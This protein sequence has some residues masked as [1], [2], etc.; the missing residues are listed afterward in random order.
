MSFPKGVGGYQKLFPHNSLQLSWYTYLF[1]SMSSSHWTPCQ[2]N[3]N[4]NFLCLLSPVCRLMLPS[5]HLLGF[6][7]LGAGLEFDTNLEN[8][9]CS[10][11]PAGLPFFNISIHCSIELGVLGNKEYKGFFLSL[12]KLIGMYL[13]VS[14]VLILNLSIH[15]AS[16]KSIF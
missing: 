8:I 3:S 10:F 16:S 12:G 14:H 5:S 7:F 13:F 11:L 4:S 6:H 1:S 9:I 15:W 2:L